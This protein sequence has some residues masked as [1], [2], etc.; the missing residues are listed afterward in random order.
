MKFKKILLTRMKYIGDVVLTTPIIRTL[1]EAYPETYISYLGDAKAVSLLQNNPFLD[2]IIPF[3]FSK[4]S[5]PYQLKM[6]ALMYSKGFDLT[7]DLY[8]NPR[9]ALMT[10]ATRATMRI[11]GDS[12]SRGKF[13]THRISDDGLLKSAIDYH[14]MSLKPLGIVPKHYKT[15]I[16]LTVEE[17]SDAKRLLQSIGVDVLKKIVAI[18]PGATWPN[19]IWLKEHFAGLIKNIIEKTDCEI[20]LSPGPHDSELMNY[21]KNQYTSRVTILPMLPVRELA[22]ILSQSTVFVS[23]DCGPMHIGVAV[24]TKTIGIFGPEPI[25]IWFP[26]DRNEGHLPMF[27]K[28]FCSPCRTTS[29][30]REGNE[31]MEC[32]KLI[33]VEEV[34]KAVRERL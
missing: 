14:Y 24:G 28:L 10:F 1:R 7:I 26:Y 5:L 4:D 16:F 13:Y 22:S 17:R 6:Y 30:F 18:H 8:S 21:L 15:E 27:K 2:E 19:K 23:N 34:F 32:M 20:I 31:T 11:G 25:E 9:S 3:D 12:K 33:T 29:C